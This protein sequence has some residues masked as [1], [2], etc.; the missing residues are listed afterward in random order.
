MTSNIIGITANRRL[1]SDRQTL[2][3]HRNWSF[4]CM[5]SHGA[6]LLLKFQAWKARENFH[7]SS[8]VRELQ[9]VGLMLQSS[10]FEEERQ[11]NSAVDHYTFW[12][13]S[14]GGLSRSGSELLDGKG[15]EISLRT[16]LTLT[17]RTLM[18]D[19]SMKNIFHFIDHKAY[20]V[21]IDAI[22]CLLKFLSCRISFCHVFLQ[23]QK[24][25]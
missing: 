17:L 9:T 1:I 3:Y 5:F 4:W 7:S 16:I 23:Q 25:L 12:G 24:A 14:S 15:T 6:I 2:S 22:R 19:S 8:E 11:F 10:E 18:T 21:L 13:T 20:G